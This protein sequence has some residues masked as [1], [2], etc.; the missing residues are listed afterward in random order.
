[1]QLVSYGYTKD[2]GRVMIAGNNSMFCL[3]S[4]LTTILVT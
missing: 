3:H 2:Y 4:L 1:M